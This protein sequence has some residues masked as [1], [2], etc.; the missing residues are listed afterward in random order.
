MEK[1]DPLVVELLDAWPTIPA[2]VRSETL[3]VLA[4]NALA[5]AISPSFAIGVNLARFAFFDPIVQ[6]GTP[7]SIEVSGQVVSFLRALARR[8]PDDEDIRALVGELAAQSD[9]FSLTWAND[10]RPA[11]YLTPAVI[12]NPRVGELEVV[13]QQLLLPGD[14]GQVLV[15]GQVAPGSTSEERIFALAAQLDAADD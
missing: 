2:F 15:I 8:E 4:S 11:D 7:R 10:Q 14:T 5:Q 9:L 12:Q 3:D 1:V 6:D 13:F